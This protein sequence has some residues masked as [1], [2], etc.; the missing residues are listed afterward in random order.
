MLRFDDGIVE[1]SREQAE[2][3]KKTLFASQIPLAFTVVDAR[4]VEHE[5]GLPGELVKESTQR[6]AI[7]FAERMQRVPF[8]VVA[9][10]AGY[11]NCLKASL[12]RR[13]GLLRNTPAPG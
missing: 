10:E 3:A 8:G 13:P 1:N 9:D 2:V 12:S 6:A 5:A 4:V 7:P 11:S